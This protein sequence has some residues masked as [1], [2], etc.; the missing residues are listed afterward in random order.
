MKRVLAFIFAMILLIVPISFSYAAFTAP[1]VSR[2][3]AAS[4]TAGTGGG[5]RVPARVT[6][7]TSTGANVAGWISLALPAGAAAKIAC[8]GLGIAGSLAAD[9][10]INKGA[11]W[12]EAQGITK[13]DGLD[14]TQTTAANIPNGKT[15][16]DFISDN[17]DEGY[18]ASSAAAANACQVDYNAAVAAAVGKYPPWTFASCGN[19]TTK[20]DYNVTIWGVYHDGSWHYYNYYW[21]KAAPPPGGWHPESYSNPMSG[22]Q[23]TSSLTAALTSGDKNAQLLALAGLDVAGAALDNP[24]HPLNLNDE[25]RKAMQA[26]LAGAVNANQLANLEAGATPNVGDGVLPDTEPNVNSLTPAQIAAAVQAALAGQGLSAAQIAAAIAA[27]QQAASGGLS[28]AEAQA[29]ISAALSAA[30]VSADA[31]GAATAAALASA[32]LATNAG[33]QTA[34]KDAIET[35]LPPIGAYVPPGA[36]APWAKPEV[37]DFA[38]LF[39]IFLDDMRNTPLFSLPGLLSSAVPAGGDC[40]YSINLSDRFGGAKTFSMCN[41]STGLSA[42]KAALL[43]VVSILAVGIVTKGG[44]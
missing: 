36:L 10:L 24:Q 9:Y 23:F 21:P 3:A 2:L 37:G 14:F 6:G 40:E 20:P 5:L 8:L 27:A 41:W 18:F 11:A 12:L 1:F 15:A 19:D 31:I 39:S 43:C 17:G 35:V 26:A 22:A 28:A 7:A 34:V 25:I 16:D 32:G 4:A 42:V 30:G 44:S 29:A 33:V 38:G 13:A